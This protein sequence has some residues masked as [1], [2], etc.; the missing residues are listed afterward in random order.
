MRWSSSVSPESDRIAGTDSVMDSV[1]NSA[2]MARSV[3]LGG[4]ADGL[5]P[6][7]KT[8][9]TARSA[10]GLNDGKTQASSAS[11]DGSTTKTTTFCVEQ[12]ANAESAMTGS[13]TSCDET[14]GPE[15]SRM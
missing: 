15:A 1:Q 7:V 14:D 10:C 12:F 8:V 4:W 5:V 9:S 2:L 3:S 11:L 6:A 13:S